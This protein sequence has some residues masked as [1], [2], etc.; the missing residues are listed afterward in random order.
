MMAAAL[1]A[2]SPEQRQALADLAYVL[3]EAHALRQA[4]QGTGDQ[5]WRARMSRMVAIEAP[6]EAFRRRLVDTFNAGYM[7][8]QAEHL[9]CD[10]ETAAAER[11][12]AESGQ[13]LAER[14]AGG[15]P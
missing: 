2:R 4:C 6:D 8:R 13:A 12:A 1:A 15:T 14:L 9:A 10:A 5:M 7:S 11:D 3:G